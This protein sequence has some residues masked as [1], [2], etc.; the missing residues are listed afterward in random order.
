MKGL[1]V[2]RIRAPE[3]ARE[4]QQPSSTPQVGAGRAKQNIFLITGIPR[5]LQPESSFNLSMTSEQRAARDKVVLPYIKAQS[6][7]WRIEYTGDSDEEDP[8]DDLDI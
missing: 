3:I 4:E 2:T 1:K 6:D 5:C 8:D 7:D